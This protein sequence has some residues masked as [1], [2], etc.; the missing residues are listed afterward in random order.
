MSDLSLIVSIKNRQQHQC[1]DG[2][3]FIEPD[4]GGIFSHRIKQLG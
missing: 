3:Q 2:D 4:F 1:P